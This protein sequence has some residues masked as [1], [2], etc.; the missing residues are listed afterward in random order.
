[1]YLTREEIKIRKKEIN[2]NI[3]AIEKERINTDLKNTDL[4]KRNAIDKE[5]KKLYWERDGVL[6]SIEFL[7]DMN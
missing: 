7:L 4:K 1:M 6:Y 3:D 2:K 5:L